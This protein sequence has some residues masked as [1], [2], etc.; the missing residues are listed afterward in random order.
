MK[1]NIIVLVT[2]T[3]RY[4]NLFD[5]AERPVRTPNLDRFAK[6][7]RPRH[8]FLH[9]ELSD[10]PKP[11]GSGDR[12]F[13]LPHYGWQPIDQ[14]GPNH[15]GKTLHRQGYKTQL[16]CDCPHLFNSRFQFGFDAAY[17]HRGQEGDKHLLHLNHPIRNEMPFDKTR[18]HAGLERQQFGRRASMD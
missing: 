8:E 1:N 6:R 17:Q 16:I 13:R 14:S 3:F 9:C 7:T 4:D 15:I 12:H 5:N 10:Y 18:P 2:D 11:N